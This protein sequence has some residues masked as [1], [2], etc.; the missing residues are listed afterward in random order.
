M[1]VLEVQLRE[2]EGRRDQM[3]TQ[4]ECRKELEE[5][6][7]EWAKES[8][9]LAS[10]DFGLRA[11]VREK[12]NVG[13]TDALYELRTSADVL[14]GVADQLAL[15]LG[16]SGLAEEV[17]RTRETVEAQTSTLHEMTEAA[18]QSSLEA[19]TAKTLASASTRAIAGVTKD[20]FASLQP[21]VDD[22]FARLAP[23]P[24]FTSLGFEMGVAY[25]SGVADPFVSDP[26]AASPP[27]LYSCS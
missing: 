5:S 8:S 6:R 27:T 24:A 18:A 20:R 15:L 12:L 22:I 23:H 14:A 19:E 13:D 2:V 25:R 26:R 21:L 11:E 7:R 10:R 9:D 17:Q 4:A 3:F 16:T 1:S